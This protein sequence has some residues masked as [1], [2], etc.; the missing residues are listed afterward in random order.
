MIECS[1]IP[2]R[3]RA[4]CQ[5]NMIDDVPERSDYAD[6]AP[7]GDLPGGGDPPAVCVS[8]VVMIQ[9][10]VGSHQNAVLTKAPPHMCMMRTSLGDLLA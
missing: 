1:L 10:I 2:Q 8:L 6:V 9:I 3:D 4:H 7:G 5:N